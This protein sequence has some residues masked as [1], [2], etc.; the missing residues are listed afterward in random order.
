[1]PAISMFYGIIVYLY[2]MD[3]KQHKTPHIHAK[4]QE[5][6][7]VLSIPDG[8]VLEGDMPKSKMKLLSAWIEL[9]KDEL[10]ANWELA[11]S[12]QLP[13]KIEPLR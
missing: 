2:F 7:V 1:M 6:E 12:G 3:N 9:H 13:Y 10:M 8:E 4:Y 11:V 5:Y